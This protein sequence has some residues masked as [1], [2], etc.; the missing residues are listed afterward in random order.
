MTAPLHESFSKITEEELDALSSDDD[1]STSSEESDNNPIHKIYNRQGKTKNLVEEYAGFEEGFDEDDPITKQM[2]TVLALKASLGIDNDKEFLL[3]HERRKH[4][5]EKAEA[6]RQKVA[7]MTVEEKLRYEQKQASSLYTNI[8]R[9]VVKAKEYAWEKPEWALKSTLRTTEAGEK[10][11]LGEDLQLPITQLPHLKR[12]DSSESDESTIGSKNKEVDANISDDANTNTNHDDDNDDDAGKD[13]SVEESVKRPC[14]EKEEKELRG[15]KETNL[16]AKVEDDEP[17]SKLKSNPKKPATTTTVF[18]KNIGW[19]KPEW[20][21]QRKLRSTQAG[22]KVKAGG[23]LQAPITHLPHLNKGKNETNT[24]SRV[25]D[26]PAPKKTYTWEKPEWAKETKLRSVNT[27]SHTDRRAALKQS[28]LTKTKSRRNLVA[29]T[30]D[31]EAKPPAPQE[32]L[33]KVKSRRGM[34]LG[35]ESI[36][37]GSVADTKTTTTTMEQP[38]SYRHLKAN[39]DTSPS[40]HTAQLRANVLVD[41]ETSH[42]ATASSS[43]VES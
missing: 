10:V 22:Q 31:E 11:K 6:E 19:E 1:S 27:A 24:P 25:T 15:K 4:E 30:V 35:I 38:K 39:D 42:E 2:K 13:N 5:R 9:N 34:A 40:F 23:D 43:D 29:V 18:Q 12:D 32:F 21:K 8:A 33:R 28:F 41:N 17:K 16:E 26:E 3:E 20:A 7:S 14:D 36:P 37:E